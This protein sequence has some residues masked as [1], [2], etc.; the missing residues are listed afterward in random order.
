MVERIVSSSG[1]IMITRQR[2]H[3]HL[4]P[5]TQHDTDPDTHLIL[6]LVVTVGNLAGKRGDR[7]V[8]LIARPGRLW[9]W[10]TGVSGPRDRVQAASAVPVRVRLARPAAAAAGV[11]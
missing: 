1:G 8:V 3:H 6:V 7:F 4:N 9:I 11:V 10:T 2:I 5:D